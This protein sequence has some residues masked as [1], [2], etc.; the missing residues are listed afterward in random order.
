MSLLRELSTVKKIVLLFLPL[1]G[2]RISV[3]YTKSL[4]PSQ[5][6]VQRWH[7]L[8]LFIILSFFGIFL[9]LPHAMYIF[10]VSPYAY[11]SSSGLEPGLLAHMHK[12][13]IYLPIQGL[14]LSKLVSQAEQ[15]CNSILTLEPPVKRL[16]TPS[17]VQVG[18]L[19]IFGA[20]PRN[21]APSRL[22]NQ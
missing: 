17:I 19:R 15:S 20:S 13:S 14:R 8:F 2:V 6:R 12:S 22:N 10:S 11:I 4:C 1:W 9:L 5:Y 3:V 21:G 7:R 16:L 18:L